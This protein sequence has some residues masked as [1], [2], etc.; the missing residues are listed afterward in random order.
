MGRLI[1]ADKLIEA[2]I[3]SQ[4]TG[5]ES[6][7]VDLIIEGIDEQ[8]TAFD[9]EAVVEELEELEQIEKLDECPMESCSECGRYCEGCYTRKAIEI[10]RKG[11]VK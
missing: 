3:A 1:D 8:P 2:F 4:N 11:G 9:V 10:V 5:K 7:P 6:F